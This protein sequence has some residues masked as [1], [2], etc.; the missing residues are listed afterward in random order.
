MPSSTETIITRLAVMPKASTFSAP[1]PPIDASKANEAKELA[2]ADE[3]GAPDVYVD[4][5]RDTCWYHWT[6]TIWVKLLRIIN[7]NG[8]YVSALKTEP[9]AELGKHRH[10]GEVKAYTVSGSWGHYE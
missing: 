7:R 1:D 10:R 3:L 5:E 4:N 2:I 8:Q 6:S 9:H